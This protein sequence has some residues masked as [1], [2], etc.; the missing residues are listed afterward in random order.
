MNNKL[1]K[2]YD[3]VWKDNKVSLEECLQ[4][5]RYL[6]KKAYMDVYGLT[7]EEFEREMEKMNNA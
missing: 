2:P 4:V 7:S 6:S 3:E 5:N 1:L